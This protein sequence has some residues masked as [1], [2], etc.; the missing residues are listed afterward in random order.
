M[1]WNSGQNNLLVWPSASS[2]S[3]RWLQTHL[4]VISDSRRKEKILT[5][6]QGTFSPPDLPQKVRQ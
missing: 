4:V 5:S 2:L 6:W 3:V 1:Y